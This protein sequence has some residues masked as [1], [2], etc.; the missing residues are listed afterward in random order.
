MKFDLAESLIIIGI[1]AIFLLII[2]G[3][4]AH[5]AMLEGFCGVPW[6]LYPCAF[7]R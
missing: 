4:F 2:A 3:A 5:T 7:V 6:N 1:T